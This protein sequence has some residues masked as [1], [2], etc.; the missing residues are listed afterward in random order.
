VSVK[1]ATRVMT[2]DVMQGIS[3]LGLRCHSALIGHGRD[4]PYSLGID[5]KDGKEFDRSIRRDRFRLD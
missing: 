5:W 4:R 3:R 1:V 2:R